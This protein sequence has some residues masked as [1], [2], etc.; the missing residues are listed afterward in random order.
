MNVALVH[1]YLTQFGGA[2]QVLAELIVLYP[3]AQIL[4]SLF[5]REIEIPGLR[6]EQV[7]ESALGRI[8]GFRNNH[9]LATPLYP[10]VMRQLGQKVKKVDIIVSDSSAWSHQIPVSAS[11][12]LVIYC[13]SPARFLYGDSHY[14]DSTPIRGVLANVWHVG[15]Q[16]YRWFDKRAFHRADVVLANSGVVARR[17]KA[18]VGVDA[19]VVY[20]PVDTEFFRPSEHAA[21]EPWLLI[22]SRLVAHKRIDLVVQTATR[23]EIPLKIIGTGRDRA[24]LETLAGPTVEFMGFQ[25]RESVRDHFRRC[26]AFVLPGVE[27]FG[28]TAVEAQASGASVI[29]FNKGGATESV[30]HGET[31]RFFDAQDQESLLDAIRHIEREPTDPAAS[32]AQAERFGLA[33]F[34]AGIERAVDTAARKRGIT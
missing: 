7:V 34:R 13:H 5:K 20:P 4:T 24:R 31:G 1:D 30:I 23:F 2:E 28:I 12:G 21:R 3:D 16:P 8:N 10:L 25:S 17:I 15:L 22:V 29:A 18:S 9:R 26:R 32:V 19:E 14:L 11:Q 27:D 33:Q 6:P